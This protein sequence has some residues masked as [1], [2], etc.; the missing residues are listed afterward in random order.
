MTIFQ[1]TRR[2]AAALALVALS[3]ACSQLG[4]IGSVLGGATQPQASQLSGTVQGVDTRS[5]Q[6]VIQATNG[7]QV[8]L[9]FDQQTQVT[10]QNRSYAVTNLERGDRITARIQQTQ[11]GGYYTDLVQV[12]QSVQSSTS[13]GDIVPSRV[14]GGYGNG[15]GTGSGTVQSLQGTVRQ[16]DRQNGLFSVDIGNYNTLTVA[17]PYN[18]SQADLNRFQTLRVGEAVRFY[19]VFLNNSRVELRRFY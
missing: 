19:G 9:L 10:Y 14:N 12:D 11:N 13:N 2:T 7:Q 16:V 1:S 5:Q 3:S 17:L 8:A 6:I 4:Q 15:N 18:P